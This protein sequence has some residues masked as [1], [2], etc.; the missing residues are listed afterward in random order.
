[1]NDADTLPQ[2]FADSIDRN[3]RIL[4][5]AFGGYGPHQFLSELQAGIF[6]SVIG[7]QPKLFVFVTAPWHAERSAC[8]IP[9]GFNGPRYKIENGQLILK[10][11]C[12]EGLARRFMEW[13][14]GSAGYRWL[15]DPYW[16]RVSHDDVELYIQIT[17]AAVKLAKT[18][19]HV[20][21][22]ILEPG[23][24]WNDY[25]DGTGFTTAAVN[26]RF[27]DGDARD[28]TQHSGRWPSNR[29]GQPPAGI[30]PE[31]LSRAEDA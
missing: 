21:V 2:L 24:E 31:E 16:R 3:L 15:I 20:P 13:L 12:Y 29:L 4:N 19:Y 7:P 1:L 18:K 11:A 6:D 27:W 28:D 26:Q 5:L 17:L 25:L 9:Y 10:G 30:D 8:K 22:I 23:W 14:A